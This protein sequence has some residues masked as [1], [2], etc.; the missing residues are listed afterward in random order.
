MQGNI[1]LIEALRLKLQLSCVLKRVLRGKISYA[2]PY[3]RAGPDRDALDVAGRPDDQVLPTIAIPA[4]HP[5]AMRHR[6]D[7]CGYRG[8]FDDKAGLR[9]DYANFTE[10]SATMHDAESGNHAE[11]GVRE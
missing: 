8:G 6:C 3:D 1:H 2:A 9:G 10:Y 4:D 5:W 11:S 7:R